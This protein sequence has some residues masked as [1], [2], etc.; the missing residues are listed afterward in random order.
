MFGIIKGIHIEGMATAIPSYVEDNLERYSSVLGEKRCKKQ[1]RLTGIERRHLSVSNQKSSD[2]V[3]EA[4]KHLLEKEKW[5]AE[6]IRVLIYLTQ[7]P[8]F[9]SPSTAFYIQKMLGVSKDCIVFDV[10]LGCAATQ[11]GIQIASAL[12]AQTGGGAKGLVLCGYGVTINEKGKKPEDQ[13]LFG[14]AGCAVALEQ[15]SDA[16][17]IPYMLRSDGQR[18]RAIF[19]DPSDLYSMD[20]EEVFSFTISDVVDDTK[21]FMERFDIVDKDVDFYA[22]H[23]PQKLI[24]DTMMSSLEVSPEKELRSLKEY[25][26]T[27]GASPIVTLCSNVAKLRDK[28]E[29][30]RVLTCGFGDG[31]SWCAMKLNVN[32][33][34]IY[35][36]IITDYVYDI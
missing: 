33:S 16:E 24:L 1:I 26:N 29:R 19:W 9:H 31:L 34:H 13:M 14:S 25:G 8:A 22:F 20:G 11:I 15:D 17:D 28:A 27:S 7:K 30:I 2:L 35:P 32:T 10:N 12:L 3:I 6:D 23:Q 21:A 18:Y 36:P 5:Q 4:A